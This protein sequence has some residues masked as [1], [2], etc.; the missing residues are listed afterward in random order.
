[1]PSKSITNSDGI[2]VI[3]V[4]RAV[5]DARVHASRT[6]KLTVRTPETT[7]TFALTRD[8]AAALALMLKQHLDAYAGHAFKGRQ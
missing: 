6:I 8:E 2:T 3:S 5:S 4:V 1:M 7:E